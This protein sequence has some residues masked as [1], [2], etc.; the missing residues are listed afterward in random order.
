MEKTAVKVIEL[1]SFGYLFDSAK[2]KTKLKIVIPASEARRE[3]NNPPFVGFRTIRNDEW[4][5]D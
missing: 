3:S 1:L 5:F 4:L 2:C